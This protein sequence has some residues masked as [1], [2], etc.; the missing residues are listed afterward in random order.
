M[1]RA[2]AVAASKVRIQALV[3]KFSALAYTCFIFAEDCQIQGNSQ[4]VLL[5]WLADESA[6]TDSAISYGSGAEIF[7]IDG[8]IRIAKTG[9]SWGSPV[10]FNED[11]LAIES[12]PGNYTPLAFFEILGVLIHEFG[13]HQESLMRS[14]GL[15]PLRHEELDTIATSVVSYLKDRT[16]T[17][18]LSGLDIPG[19]SPE[20]EVNVY[21]IDIEWDNGVRNIW[22]HVFIDSNSAVTEISHDLTLGLKC[23]KEYRSGHLT[24]SGE[25]EYVSLRQVRAAEIKVSAGEVNIEQEVGDASAMCIDSQMGVFEVFNDYKNGHMHLGF[26]RGADGILSYHPGD[27]S[28]RATP[29]PDEHY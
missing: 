7:M 11:L 25:A 26:I 15:K 8:A 23:P 12:S 2:A 5:K 1:T 13:H 24:F 21:H 17:I 18:N 3:P 9:T 4:E 19:L 22:S 28:F 14:N 10:M 6:R 29:P 20:N 16:R 27:A